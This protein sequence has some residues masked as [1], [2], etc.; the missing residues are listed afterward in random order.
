MDRD[1]N[2]ERG[3]GNDCFAPEGLYVTS[4]NASIQAALEAGADQ[5]AMGNWATSPLREN[6]QTRHGCSWCG[7]TG[8]ELTERTASLATLL[9]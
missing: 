1:G 3:R 4:A 5:I 2:R 7:L 6:Q 8:S 9:S